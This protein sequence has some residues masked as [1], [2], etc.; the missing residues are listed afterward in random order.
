MATKT[1]ICIC[2]TLV[3]TS[4][5]AAIRVRQSK[6]MEAFQ[7]NDMY[8]AAEIM[9]KDSISYLPNVPAQRGRQGTY[10]YMLGRFRTF[11]IGRFMIAQLLWS[12]FAGIAAS[13]PAIMLILYRIISI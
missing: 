10:V 4:A 9:S 8:A 7:N 6:A 12:I 13:Q 3:T 11:V 5:I 1:P 2:G